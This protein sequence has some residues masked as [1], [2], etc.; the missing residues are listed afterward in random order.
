VW[1]VTVSADAVTALPGERFDWTQLIWFLAG[2]Q[3]LYFA[4]QTDAQLEIEHDVIT[5]NIAVTLTRPY[6]YLLGRFAVTFANTLLS[7]AV[8]FPAAFIVAWIA[9]GTVAVTPFGVVSFI[10]AFLLRTLLFFA[11]QAI[12]GLATFWI[13]KATAF[14]W[15]LGLLIMTF[16]GGV[17]PLGFWPESAR[18]AAE[19]TPFPVMMYYPAKLLVEPSFELVVATL[20][21]GIVWLG[22]LGGGVWLIYSRA[23]RRLDINGG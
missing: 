12:A 9:S 21:R 20:T 8:A 2:G 4:V 6:D 16:G 14:V 17:V 1:E 5:G 22:I 19:L 3:T 18:A 23:L 13:E 10:L 7:F 11:L 15:V